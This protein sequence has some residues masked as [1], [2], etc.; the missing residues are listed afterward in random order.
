MT[1]QVI[2]NEITLDVDEHTAPVDPFPSENERP[3]WRCYDDWIERGGKK[4]QPGV[5]FHGIKNNGDAPPAISN[6]WVCA[7]LHVV[8]MTANQE[9]ADH[10]R[11]LRYQNVSGNWKRWSMPMQMLAGDGVEVLGVL[12]AEGLALDRK[13]KMRILDYINAQHPKERLRAAGTT[14]WHGSAFVL[15][16]QVI[17]ADNIWYQA[18]ERTAPYSVAGTLDGWQEHVAAKA[19]GNP[20]LILAI[21]AA[22]AGCL[23][24][25]LGVDGG[26]LHIFGDSSAG[27]TT[28]LMA[29]ISVW[30]GA[31]FRR[32]WRSTANGLEGAAKMHSSTLLALD[33][34][35]EVN[36]RELYE[37][38]YALMN[39][40]GKTR[41]N[42]R[43][44]A[45]QVNRWR[46]FLLSTGEVTVSSRLA[47]GGLEAKAGQ[48][49]RLLD[50]PIS[51]THGAF[52]NLHGLH[53]GAAF[54]DAL[55]SKTAEHYGHAGGA[56]VRFLIEQEKGGGL[57]LAAELDA[58][59]GAFRAND[60][61]ETRAA[62][63]FAIC[64]L[65]G[66]LAASSGLL[67]WNAG[68]AVDAAVKGFGLWREHRGAAGRNAEDVAILRA[69]DDFIGTH[70][71]SR[72]EDFQGGEARTVVNRAG[73]ISTDGG[74]P[75]YMFLPAG[76][77]EAAKGYDIG[78]VNRVLDSVGALAEKDTGK[79]AK[80]KRV[81]K[82]GT[83][84]LYVIDPEKLQEAL[85]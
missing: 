85:Q 70:G 77:R 30:G 67:P 21:S 41:A 79:Y 42:A 17:G 37:A 80:T 19:I 11:L 35:G 61:Q 12:L 18:S 43:G 38:V 82:G 9:D 40:H 83:Q 14:G 72:F 65:A 45:R 54:S 39:G 81:P 31:P 73:F 78:K 15:P 62:R 16:D 5:Y 55:R 7:P 34:I 66:E 49:L 74:A 63:V 48:G 75:L 76:L 6:D 24:D 2:E 8:A 47:T 60:G 84:K 26:G 51:G 29:A 22:L 20:M 44:E 13:N 64:A 28:V 33:E 46:V 59:L 56:F 10:G 25:R 32:T 23:L 50:I 52:D 4:W 1:E 69:V 27:K 57:D 58:V 71:N 36:P 68:V 53:S 3:C